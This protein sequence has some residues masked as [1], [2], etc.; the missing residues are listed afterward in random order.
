M[1]ESLTNSKIELIVFDKH[2]GANQTWLLLVVSLVFITKLNV[3]VSQIDLHRPIQSQLLIDLGVNIF[4]SLEQPFQSRS[5]LF[6]V[7]PLLLWFERGGA[8]TRVIIILRRAFNWNL[9]SF[10]IFLA[11]LLNTIGF[12]NLSHF[13]LQTVF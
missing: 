4:L 6:L 1:V 12:P 3:Y 7:D 11:N 13:L 9:I 10:N 8:G 5:C 2:T